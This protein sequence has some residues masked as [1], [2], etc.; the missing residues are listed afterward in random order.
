MSDFAT[1]YGPWALVA[2]ASEGVGSTF[3]AEVARRGLNVVLLSRRP[4]VLDEIAAEITAESSVEARTLAVD[5]TAPDAAH[6]II[7]AT[8]DID[9]GLLM[10]NAGANI[11]HRPFLEASRQVAVAQVQRN[12]VV[13]TELC[14]HFAAPMVARGR[15]GII[16]RHLGRGDRRRAQHGHLQRHESVSTRS[17]PSRCGRRSTTPGSTS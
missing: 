3:A 8:D 11:E 16:N 7:E 9:V 12:C 4:A 5:L 10:Y 15:G 13:P 1:T 14:H 17:S 6:R 2:G